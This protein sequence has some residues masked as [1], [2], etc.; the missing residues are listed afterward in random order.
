[1][2]YKNKMHDVEVIEMLNDLHL[3]YNKDDK[4]VMGLMIKQKKEGINE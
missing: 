2:D 4:Q 1:M 3:Y